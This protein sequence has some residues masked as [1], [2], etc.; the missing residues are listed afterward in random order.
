M[1]S[2]K[3]TENKP[4]KAIMCAADQLYEILLHH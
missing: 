4:R 2:Y 1:A 3:A